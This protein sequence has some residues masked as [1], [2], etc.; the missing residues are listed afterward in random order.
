[1][2]ACCILFQGAREMRSCELNTILD[3]GTRN[4]SATAGILVRRITYNF[5]TCIAVGS[6]TVC[7]DDNLKEDFLISHLCKSFS[8]D[9][10]FV[11]S[12]RVFLGW[13]ILLV[14]VVVH[15]GCNCRIRPRDLA[16]GLHGETQVQGM[17]SANS[18]PGNLAERELWALCICYTW[19]ETEA[20]AIEYIVLNTVAYTPLVVGM[21]CW[22]ATLL[23]MIEN[24]V[25]QWFGTSHSKK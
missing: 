10:W 20:V 2:N 3:W 9:R 15:V 21:I 25:S 12:D 11:K 7:L 17:R 8:A 4:Q 16:E 24:D 6:F 14:P 18:T 19:F 13:S 5:S 23:N 1:M 22:I